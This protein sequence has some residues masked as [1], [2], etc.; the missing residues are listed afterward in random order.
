MKR[1]LLA[2]ARAS[3]LG[4]LRITEPSPGEWRVVIGDHL[5]GGGDTVRQAMDS[6]DPDVA[7]ALIV[8]ML[9]G[10]AN[11]TTPPDT[12]PC[13]MAL[14]GDYTGAPTD[15]ELA[16]DA[17]WIDFCDSRAPT[18]AD[19]DGLWAQMHGGVTGVAA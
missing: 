3:R 16:T 17:D 14:D 10:A 1:T 15:D 13:G 6:I 7:E 5:L 19:V 4:H 11:D 12:D 2:L 8:G 9:A 18:D